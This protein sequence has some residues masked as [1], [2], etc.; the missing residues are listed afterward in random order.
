VSHKFESVLR[1][2][3]RQS[4]PYKDVRSL[5]VN[6]A[7]DANLSSPLSHRVLI[8]A[9][10]IDPEVQGVLD[11]KPEFFLQGCVP[12]SSQ[13]FLEALEVF[14]ERI[15]VRSDLNDMA[16]AQ[17][18]IFRITCFSVSLNIFSWW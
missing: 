5:S 3:I 18:W 12:S 6:T 7:H 16:V 10:R 9:N 17:D 1:Q 15:A 11:R 13:K 4:Q 8:D 14:Y 2:L